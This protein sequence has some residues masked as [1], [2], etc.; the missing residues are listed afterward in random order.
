MIDCAVCNKRI[1][2]GFFVAETITD[3]PIKLL[4]L[5]CGSING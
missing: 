3:P 1:K 5:S 2:K 4:C